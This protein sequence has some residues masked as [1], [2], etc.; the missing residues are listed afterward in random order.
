MGDTQHNIVIGCNAG[1]PH[2]THAYDGYKAGVRCNNGSRVG[3][4]IGG[5]GQCKVSH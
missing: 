4:N 3:H 5:V 2:N 1:V